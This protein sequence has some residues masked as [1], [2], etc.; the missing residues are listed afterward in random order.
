MSKKIKFALKL[1]DVDVRTLESLQENFD[2]EK[3]V[4]YFL[5][6]KLLTW[7][8]DRYYENEAEKVRNLDKNSVEFNKQ[9]CEI[10]GVE[11]NSDSEVDLEAVTRTSENLAKLQ[12]LTSDKEILNHA[13]QVAF[14]Q[15]DLADLLDDDEATI[16]LCGKQFTIPVRCG[17]HKYIGILG[18]PDIKISA[19]TLD[20][21]SAVGIVFEN[22]NLPENLLQSIPEAKKVKFANNKKKLSYSPSK[23][24]DSKLNDSD[25]KQA[26]KFFEA[27]Q[28]ILGNF[29]FEIDS[30][31]RPLS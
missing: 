22:V 8:E 26:T 16:Y 4:A 27:T 7:L 11:Y 9:L 31:S 14:S 24:L 2:F 21:L 13:A 10:F 19:A 23:I 1:N 15:E 3:V 17:N 18:T 5:D 29:V 25:R 6:G 12:Q 20:D 30:I 28:N